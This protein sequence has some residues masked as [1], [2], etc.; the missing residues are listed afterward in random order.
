MPNNPLQFLAVIG[1]S[2]QE[3]VRRIDGLD[4]ER[5][6][7]D[8]DAYVSA[9]TNY[10]DLLRSLGMSERPTSGL[11]DLLGG[12]YANLIAETERMKRRNGDE[13]AT[14]LEAVSQLLEAAA[15]SRQYFKTMTI[16]QNIAKLSRQIAVSGLVALLT[17]FYVAFVYRTKPDATI[18][19]TL[20]PWLA[21]VGLT[22][23]VSPVVVLLVH[24][25]RISTIMWYTVSVGPFV[26]PEQ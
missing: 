1:Q 11:T 3:Q 12:Q 10:G 4:S 20:L 19:P 5:P 15:I 2:L 17:A 7:G 18:D 24:I 16:Q 26:R 14:E 9:V 21:S 25:F 23:V 8:V 13:A 6:Q 22:V